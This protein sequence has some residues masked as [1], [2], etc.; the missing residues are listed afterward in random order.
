MQSV[1]TKHLKPSGMG[2]GVVGGLDEVSAAAGMVVDRLV[3][4]E[5]GCLVVVDWRARS[6]AGVGGRILNGSC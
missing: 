3:V 1:L 4:V 5:A 2:A 6:R